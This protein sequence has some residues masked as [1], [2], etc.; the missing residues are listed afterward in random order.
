MAGVTGAVSVNAGPDN[1]LLVLATGGVLAVG[2]NAYGKLG[3]GTTTS[4][5]LPSRRV[6]PDKCR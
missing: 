5:L 1:S 2:S 4:R 3:D 6:R